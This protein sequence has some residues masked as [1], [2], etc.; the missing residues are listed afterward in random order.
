M[1]LSGTSGAP[2]SVRGRRYTVD[3]AIAGADAGQRLTSDEGGGVEDEDEDEDEEGAMPA[4]RA[5]YGAAR[6]GR[7][8]CCCTRSKLGSRLPGSRVDMGGLIEVGAGMHGNDDV[9]TAH[10]G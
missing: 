4:G 7:Y 1:Y 8:C 9:P 6:E 2:S 5:V 10:V 3:N